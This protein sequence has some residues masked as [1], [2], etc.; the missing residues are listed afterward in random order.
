MDLYKSVWSGPNERCSVRLYDQLSVHIALAMSFK[1]LLS[2]L[3]IL[4]HC[5]T[6]FPAGPGVWPNGSSPVPPTSD[7]QIESIYNLI[8]T[9]D[10][11]NWVNKFDVQDVRPLSGPSSKLRLTYG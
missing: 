10:A 11:S 1:S 5:A 2:S 4:W 6:A 8:D 7:V 3:P 9:Y